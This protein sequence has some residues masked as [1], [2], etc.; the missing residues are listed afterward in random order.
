MLELS[1]TDNLPDTIA[2]SKHS[3]DPT[4]L[5]L[6]FFFFSLLLYSSSP[7]APSQKTSLPLFQ[8]YLDSCW[9]GKQ[10]QACQSHFHKPGLLIHSHEIVTCQQLQQ[11]DQSGVDLFIFLFPSFKSL[12]LPE[13]GKSLL[14][15][16]MYAALSC[17][18]T[19]SASE[20]M[21]G[22]DRWGREKDRG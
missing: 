21:W 20:S 22:G 19:T 4:L 15:I 18:I 12:Y 8:L 11:L 7:R 14:C 6:F 9:C 16:D 1:S 5:M 2:H 13:G 3:R 17:N 10:S